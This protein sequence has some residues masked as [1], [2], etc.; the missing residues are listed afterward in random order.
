[1][2]ESG[3]T[4]SG[5]TESGDDAKPG[6][7]SDGTTLTDV[8]DG[9]RD[10][11]YT[12]DFGTAADGQ[13]LCDTCETLSTAAS[14]AVASFRRMEGASDPD[15]MM[16]IVAITCPACGAEGTLVLG[17]GPTSSAFDT[18]VLQHLNQDSDAET[19]LPPHAAP[20][21]TATRTTT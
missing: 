11:G 8:I 10:A 18:E 17:Y 21:E 20:D 15:D 14:L 1:M 6:A 16:A 5:M 19:Q 3:M 4:E 12:A 9:Y 13:V 7:P 2:T